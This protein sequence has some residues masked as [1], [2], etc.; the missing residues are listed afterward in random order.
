MSLLSL[1]QTR[2]KTIFVKRPVSFE[3][4]LGTAKKTYLDMGS[5]DAYIASRSSTESYE[6]NR[7]ID[8]EV[9]TAYVKGD[10]DVSV[11]DRF[12]LDGV[13]FEITGKRT[14][15]MRQAGDRH[16]Y[17]IISAVSDKGI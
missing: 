13:T 17:H 5:M 8:Q 16:F 6:G 14:P 4:A 2:G 3:D 1:I 15:G 11:R 7:Q 10:S 9:V 12:T